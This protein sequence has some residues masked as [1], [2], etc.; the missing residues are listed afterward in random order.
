MP[1][2]LEPCSSLA[3]TYCIVASWPICTIQRCWLSFTLRYGTKNTYFPYNTNMYIFLVFFCHT[4]RPAKNVMPSYFSNRGMPI[5]LEILIYHDAWVN[6]PN[7]S[8]YLRDS[9]HNFIAIMIYTN[10]LVLLRCFIP[11]GHYTW[12]IHLVMPSMMAVI[13]TKNL[14]YFISTFLSDYYVWVIHPDLLLPWQFW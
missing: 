6:H 12:G 11:I 7:M 5:F 8:L 3:W 9:S 1:K 4:Q 14:L 10:F 13:N 2:Y